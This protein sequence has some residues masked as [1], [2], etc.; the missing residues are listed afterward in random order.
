M[1]MR[2]KIKHCEEK[3]GWA[4][5]VTDSDNSEFRHIIRPGGSAEFWIHSTKQIR[6]N[7]I[8]NSQP[9][10]HKEKKEETI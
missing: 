8:P 5:E 3:S 2:I 7:E 4:L 9:S 6:I 10:E 1:T